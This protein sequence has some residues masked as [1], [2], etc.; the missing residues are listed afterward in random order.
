MEDQIKKASDLLDF[1]EAQVR[2]K[3]AT[4]EQVP[5]LACMAQEAVRIASARLGVAM[6]HR[7]KGGN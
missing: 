2:S 4:C 6:E 5:E 3:M 7:I 1:A